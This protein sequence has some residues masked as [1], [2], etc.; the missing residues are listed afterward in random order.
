MS[1]KR[2]TKASQRS[3]VFQLERALVANGRAY[4]EGPRK[5]WSLHDLKTITARTEAQRQMLLAF[6]EG[7]HVV[8]SG[9]PG[10][11]KTFLAIF[12]ALRELLDPDS[13]ITKVIILR[14]AVPTR[15]QGFVPGELDEKAA[16]FEAPYGPMFQQLLGRPSSYQDMKEA[17]KVEFLT[18]SN[19]RGVTWDNTVVVVDE[20]QSLNFHEINTAITRLGNNSRIML[21]GDIKQTDLRSSKTDVTGM[22]DLLRVVDRMR[23]F[24]TV[25]F[26][27]HD[28]VRSPMVK[29]W[30]IAC[31]DA[32][33]T[34]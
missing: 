2:A 19:I 7:Y 5:N 33:V 26:T 23:S 28:I 22:S 13:D 16:I 24:S 27:R 14:S 17:G 34:L 6:M 21:C 9:T 32:N 11:G 30:I 15:N 29:E 20:C 12:L 8:A 25:S 1:R 18:T 10:T 4:S 31:E 3:N